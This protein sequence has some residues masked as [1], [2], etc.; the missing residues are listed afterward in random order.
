MARSKKANI[1][2]IVNLVSML[3]LILVALYYFTY[4]LE[5]RNRYVESLE[6]S[7]QQLGEGIGTAI[8]MVF[9]ILASIVQGVLAVMLLISAIGL[10]SSGKRGFVILGGIA[11]ILSPAPFIFAL[12]LTISPFSRVL[13]VC[14]SA[15]Y[16]AC[17]I[18]DCVQNKK[19][20]KAAAELVD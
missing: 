5:Y 9:L 20:K 15:A 13:Y 19:L 4:E 6:G 3:V 11:K 10:F 18:V 1:W 14:L 17:G 16:L 7:D 8:I 2:A 12:L